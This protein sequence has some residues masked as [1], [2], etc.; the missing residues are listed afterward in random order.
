MTPQFLLIPVYNKIRVT[1]VDMQGWIQRLWEVLKCVIVDHANYEWDTYL[2]ASNGL[3]T[4]FAI[5]LK[6]HPAQ[7]SFLTRHHPRYIWRNSLRYNGEVVLDLFA[8]ATDMQHSMQFYDVLWYNSGLQ[9][10][11]AQ[12][13][14]A[15]Q[16]SIQL[17]QMLTIR[18]LE[19]L[20]STGQGPSIAA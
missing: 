6:G 14:S 19:F 8:D 3:K 20:R 17:N 7:Q 5:E 16:L 1:F 4:E 13:V 11:V 15:P 9:S 2:V 12:V 18:F 10:L